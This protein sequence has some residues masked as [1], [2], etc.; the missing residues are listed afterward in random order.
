MQ[1]LKKKVRIFAHDEPIESDKVFEI[2]SPASPKE[3]TD[4]LL[5]RLASANT[6]KS[7]VAPPSASPGHN[8]MKAAGRKRE[9]ASDEVLQLLRELIAQG[10]GGDSPLVTPF[11]CND[12]ERPSEIEAERAPA[13]VSHRDKH[14]KPPE[15]L[16]NLDEDG[17][18]GQPQQQDKQ[19]GSR[20]AEVEHGLNK[21]YYES[22]V[23]PRARSPTRPQSRSGK[24]TS[25]DRASPHNSPSSSQP[26]QH[27]P[28]AHPAPVWASYYQH[29]PPYHPLYTFP[30]PHPFSVPPPHYPHPGLLS[31]GQPYYAVPPY[32]AGYAS[33]SFPPNP[34]DQH[35]EPGTRSAPVQGGSPWSPLSNP[36]QPSDSYPR[37]PYPAQEGHSPYSPRGRENALG[38]ALHADGMRLQDAKEPLTPKSNRNESLRSQQAEI[39]SSSKDRHDRSRADVPRL[40]EGRVHPADSLD[41]P[42]SADPDT[43]KQ[44]KKSSRMNATEKKKI[45]DTE[46]RDRVNGPVSVSRSRGERSSNGKELQGSGPERPDVTGGQSRST[47]IVEPKRSEVSTPDDAEERGRQGAVEARETKD[48]HGPTSQ[49]VEHREAYL[50][51][52]PRNESEPSGKADAWSGR[53]RRK[54]EVQRRDDHTGGRPDSKPRS[55]EDARHADR[56]RHEARSQSQHE[57]NSSDPKAKARMR[58]EAAQMART[59]EGT[60]TNPEFSATGQEATSSSMLQGDDRLVSKLTERTELGGHGGKDMQQSEDTSKAYESA[61]V[62][63][64]SAE[65]A[66]MAKRK[67][68][69]EERVGMRQEKRDSGS[70]GL[71]QERRDHLLQSARGSN[72][73]M[74]PGG[75]EE[76][77]RET[78]TEVPRLSKQNTVEGASREN[79]RGRSSD[80]QMETTREQLLRPELREGVHNDS[81]TDDTS[82]MRRDEAEE[83]RMN[84]R[85]ALSK[86][87]RD[88]TQGQSKP[89]ISTKQKRHGLMNRGDADTLRRQRENALRKATARETYPSAVET[90]N[91]GQ[92][93]ERNATLASFGT[94]ETVPS[95]S[96]SVLKAAQ[97]PQATSALPRESIDLH[98]LKRRTVEDPAPSWSR[99]LV[100][101]ASC[102]GVYE[103]PKEGLAPADLPLDLGNLLLS[104]LQSGPGYS[105]SSDPVQSVLRAVLPRLIPTLV[106]QKDV[107][108]SMRLVFGEEHAEAF[109]TLQMME[110]PCVVAC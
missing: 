33:L 41:P 77:R 58:A 103:R 105:S 2:D 22:P 107:L 4:P 66:E 27:W 17:R 69:C 36:W 65:L 104:E 14:K 110:Q 70:D 108:K 31:P 88:N 37:E 57:E 109:S 78:P 74:A 73:D 106:G 16:K 86:I 99:C 19:G 56:R 90:S 96:R 59:R 102:I 8:V 79:L 39:Y 67:R 20:I 55:K 6:E 54:D 63:R 72:N 1:K 60:V 5:T 13:S 48:R 94:P 7:L 25:S 45:A 47:E 97:A 68:R 84:R 52:R 76:P 93:S 10:R 40:E 82:V 71:R 75:K 24:A 9:Q 49:S 101:I 64:G 53:D 34:H 42:R 91:F 89:D 95:S 46:G 11:P 23:R 38:L 87:Q 28:V 30:V 18:A 100:S 43:A 15:E 51:T 81:R 83:H 35:N 3:N 32:S 85:D 92:P 21:S 80:H 61:N 44:L 12:P 50:A 62:V 98:D 26:Y 29:A